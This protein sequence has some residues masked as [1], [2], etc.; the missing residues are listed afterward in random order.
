MSLIIERGFVIR[1]QQLDGSIP[2]FSGDKDVKDWWKRERASLDAWRDAW[3]VRLS[4]QTGLEFP[5]EA[6]F[7]DIGGS[8]PQTEAFFLEDD[9]HIGKRQRWTFLRPANDVADLSSVIR[10][11]PRL[12]PKIDRLARSLELDRDLILRGIIQTNALLDYT[13]FEGLPVLGD[14]LGE[15]TASMELDNGWSMRLRRFRPYFNEANAL[16]G[17]LECYRK[18]RIGRIITLQGGLRLGGVVCRSLIYDRSIRQ[19]QEL[20]EQDNAVSRF[21][22]LLS[23]VLVLSSHAAFGDDYERS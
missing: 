8:E 14:G 15:H 17:V 12:D 4:N 6:A 9:G 20:R 10:S 7:L 21:T 11:F 16:M 5:P 23:I 13:R 1:P 2:V 3:R 19:P 18:V 22:R